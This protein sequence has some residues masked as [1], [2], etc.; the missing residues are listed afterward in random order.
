[1]KILHVVHGYTPAVGG[2]QHM[3]QQLSERFTR[4]FGDDVTVYTTVAHSN[5][6]FRDRRQPAMR[7]GIEKINGV[8]VRRFPVFNRFGALRLNLARVMH[9][10]HLPYED[11]ARGCYFGPIIPGL[12]REIAA[13]G[14]DVIMA[15][16]FPLLH[17]HN[18]IRG[19]QSGHIPVILLGAFHTADRWGFDRKMVYDDIRACDAYVAYTG[20]ERDYLAARGLTVERCEVIPGGVDVAF[21][22]GFDRRAARARL[23]IGDELMIASVAQHLPHKR[24]DVLIS[25][26]P[27]I[28]RTQP[29]ARLLIVGRTGEDTMRLEALRDALSAKERERIRLI[30]DHTPAEK[31]EVL[32]ACDIFAMLSSHEAFGLV[33]AE[34]WACGKPVIGSSIGAISSV[35]RDGVDG[36]LAPH[37]ADVSAYAQVALDL[38]KHPQMRMT[39]GVN[40]QARMRTECDLDIVARRYHELYEQTTHTYAHK[41]ALNPLR[42]N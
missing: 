23:G 14:A 34:A 20:Y 30:V 29:D 21:F 38:W 40:G 22:A 39:M 37:D 9:K 16:A 3:V 19:G 32:A 33:Y 36:Y 35:I 15:S 6:Y 5:A 13:S 26:M 27:I 8:T 7:P 4:D 25:A 24:L 41:I 1:M 31:A 17:M 10:L 12:A 11:W 2:T 42:V 18:A 28:W